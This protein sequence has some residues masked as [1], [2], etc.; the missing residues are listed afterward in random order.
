MVFQVLED[1]LF[2]CLSVFVPLTYRLSDLSHA[3]RL[4]QSP[5]LLIS[6]SG[7]WSRREKHKKSTAR[8]S[9]SS[10]KLSSTCRQVYHSL[11]AK[12]WACVLREKC[13]S[14]CCLVLFCFFVFITVFINVNVR[15]YLK[16]YSLKFEEIW[17]KSRSYCTQSM[18]ASKYILDKG[19]LRHNQAFT[20]K[21]SETSVCY[22]CINHPCC[23]SNDRNL[24][25]NLK[26]LLFII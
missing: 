18:I 22:N 5:A 9:R 23:N 6:G 3:L 8:A 7:S 21:I 20:F 24:T 11:R 26:I 13:L 15:E 25:F 14:P 4:S 19:V 1:P 10:K 17:Q 12:S 16:N 2:V